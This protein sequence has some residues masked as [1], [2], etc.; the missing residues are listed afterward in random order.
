MKIQE[1]KIRR[2]CFV[3]LLFTAISGVLICIRAEEHFDVTNI[4]LFGLLISSTLICVI[5]KL[6]EGIKIFRRV[7]QALEVE[8]DVTT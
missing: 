7:R 3:F 1:K 8:S 4:I 2:C 6:V 5:L